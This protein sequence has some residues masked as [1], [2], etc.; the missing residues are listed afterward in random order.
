MV[1]KGMIHRPLKQEI[2]GGKEPFKNDFTTVSFGAVTS[3][4]GM[5]S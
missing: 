2:S 3:L 4:A 1:L 5:R